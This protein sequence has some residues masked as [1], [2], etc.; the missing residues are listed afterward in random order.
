MLCSVVSDR[1]A[2]CSPSSFKKSKKTS[3][4][5]SAAL[6]VDLVET[7]RALTVNPDKSKIQKEC[8]IFSNQ[9]QL[10]LRSGS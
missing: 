6:T 8:A 4:R 9:I 2:A 5:T 3:K 1:G 10:S 7:T